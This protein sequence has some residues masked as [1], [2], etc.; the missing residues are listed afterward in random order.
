M[1]TVWQPRLVYDVQQ[2]SSAP[3]AA[4]KLPL[5]GLSLSKAIQREH[6]SERS[7]GVASGCKTLA[8]FFFTARSFADFCLLWHSGSALREVRVQERQ[9]NSS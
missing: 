9:P 3:A 1:G 8:S 5:N 4:D 6:T 7:V 2:L